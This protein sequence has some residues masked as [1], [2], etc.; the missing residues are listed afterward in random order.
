L[1]HAVFAGFVVIAVC[2]APAS[3]AIQDDARAVILADGFGY[4]LEGLSP[5]EQRVV[6]ELASKARQANAHVLTLDQQRKVAEEEQNLR[7][8]NRTSIAQRKQGIVAKLEGSEG[9]TGVVAL[10]ETS[11]EKLRRQLLE[12]EAL[13]DELTLQQHAQVSKLVLG[14]QEVNARSFTPAQREQLLKLVDKLHPTVNRVDGDDNRV[15]VPEQPSPSPGHGLPGQPLPPSLARF[16]ALFNAVGE[17]PTEKCTCSHIGDSLVV[18]AGH[19]FNKFEF[20][21]IDQPCGQTTVRWGRRGNGSPVLDSKCTKI[22]IAEN[23]DY[24]DFALFQVDKAPPAH[25]KAR[26]E[27]RPIDHSKIAI[28]AYPEGRSLVFSPPCEARPN[29]A[30]GM[31]ATAEMLAHQC[32]TTDG[33]SGAPVFDST[34][35]DLVAIHDGGRL[36]GT[37]PD[38]KPFA[39]N[40]ATLLD[41]AGLKDRLSA[42]IHP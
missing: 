18:T 1:V 22:L 27:P 14:F 38:G 23:S 10:S 15:D 25:F 32:D 28:L 4:L 19:C 34:T 6:F 39:W 13:S 36:F 35:S 37:Y 29:T 11:K 9:R 12:L 16:E 40:R 7:E 20:S 2:A 41:A 17:L 24:R 3:L 31:D 33:S 26:I 21:W 30:G 42:F 5:D 8:L